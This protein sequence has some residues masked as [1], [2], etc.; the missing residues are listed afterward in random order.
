MLKEPKLLQFPLHV[1]SQGSLSV[2]EPESNHIPFEIKRIFY[3]YQ[4]PSNATRGDHA[5]KQLQEVLIAVSG[6][7]TVKLTTKEQTIEFVL[8]DPSQGLYV[9]PL[10]WIEIKDIEPLSI[11]LVLCSD[12]FQEADYYREKTEFEKII[13]RAI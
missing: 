1:N 9:P 6:S 4:I 13:G 8:D 10:T 12:I 3:T 5:H 2:I 11:C 7:F